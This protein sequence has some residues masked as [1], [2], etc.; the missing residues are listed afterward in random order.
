NVVAGDPSSVAVSAGDGQSA[1]V[2]TN[3][4][5]VLAAK[6]TDAGGNPVAGAT[7]TFTAPSSG[8]SGTFANG[9]ATTNA[10]TDPTGVATASAFTANTT[11]GSYTVSASVSGVA[12]QTS[13]SL[14][15][16]ATTASKLAFIQQ[17]GSASGGTAFLTQPWVAV[18]DTYGNVVT[19]D[20]SSVTMTLNPAAGANNP[21]LQN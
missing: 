10:T 14:T 15:N 20:T 17:P 13:F 11:A 8:A 12:T 16:K 5:T 4:G 21:K 2:T 1:T 3:F 7:V 6:V 19:T 18:E 9:S